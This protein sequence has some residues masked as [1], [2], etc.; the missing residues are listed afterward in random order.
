MASNKGISIYISFEYLDEKAYIAFGI[1]S[2]NIQLRIGDVF[3]LLLKKE[4][5]LALYRY[6]A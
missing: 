3:S 5:T 2:A 4:V 6:Q 1:K